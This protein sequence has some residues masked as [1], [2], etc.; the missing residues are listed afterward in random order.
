MFMLTRLLIETRIII[1]MSSLFVTRLKKKKNRKTVFV[2]FFFSKIVILKEQKKNRKIIFVVFFSSIVLFSIEKKK[3]KNNFCWYFFRSSF[4]IVVI[5]IVIYQFW[6][7]ICH[8]I[9]SI[10]FFISFKNIA[11]MFNALMKNV[12]NLLKT[13]LNENYLTELHHDSFSSISFTS[14]SSFDAFRSRKKARK[15]I[16]IK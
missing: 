11:I 1:I 13:R 15:M 12:V 10:V 7:S 6:I 4:V 14:K 8:A 5:I 3:S 9:I 16:S 2:V